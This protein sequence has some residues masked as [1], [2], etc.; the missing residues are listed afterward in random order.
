MKVKV[1]KKELL[2]NFNYIIDIGYC[3]A[4]YLLYY[5]E[6]NYYTCSNL[7][8]WYSDNY[9][10]NNN[11]LISTGYNPISKN[12]NVNYDLIKKYDDKAHKIFLSDLKYETKK[13]K[14]NILL[15]LFIK[16]VL[17]ND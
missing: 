6:P 5:Q 11:I 12:C 3:N 4:Q 16:E 17:K 15:N 13:R 7:Y 1:T 8:G 14:V 10:I 9:Q 2:N